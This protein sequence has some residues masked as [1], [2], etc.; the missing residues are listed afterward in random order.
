MSE[1]K[2]HFNIKIGSERNFGFVFGLVFTVYA[3]LPLISGGSI[4]LW[5]FVLSFVFLVVALVRPS[6]LAVPNRLWAKLGMFM[7]IIVSPIVMG[8]L[9][10]VSVV[11]TGLLVRAFGKDLLCQQFDKSSDTYWIIREDANDSMENQF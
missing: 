6:I 8:I 7:G 2:S 4:R 3:A 10:F 11:P 9:F 1:F 5:A